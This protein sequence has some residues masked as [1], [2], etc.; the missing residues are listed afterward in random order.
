MAKYNVISSDSHVAEPGDLWLRYIDPAFRERAPQLVQEAD[1]DYWIC[2]GAPKGN[3]GMI[4]PAGRKSEELKAKGR[5][6]DGRAGGWDAEARLK[7]MAVDGVDAEVL[8]PTIAIR[9]FR[10]NDIDYQ[11]ACFRGYN[12]WMADFT[13]THPDKLKGLAL[14]T[15][16]DLERG[17]AQM[18]EGRALGLPGAVIAIS[19]DED[20]PYNHAYYEPLWDAAEDLAMPLS[21]HIQAGRKNALENNYLI[22]YTTTPYWVQRSLAQLIFGGVFERHP[23]LKVISAES[24]IGWIPT[25]LSRMDHAYNRH[26]FHTGGFDYKEEVP[27]STF[28]HR[29]VYATFMRD[30]PGVLAREYVGVGNL[31]WASDYPHS[32]STWPD[33]QRVIAEQFR[34]VP[35]GDRQRIVMENA[36]QLYGLNLN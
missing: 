35:V 14:V 31:M 15:V 3:A 18:R 11:D 19:P 25:F 9:M 26:R 2:E 24:D 21:L 10:L 17:I 28:F 22:D 34:D 1:A 13:G 27:P 32:D 4:A 30:A 5:Y 23:K 33:S 6:A 29:H 12:R 36:A 16:Q 8:Y 7:D 20:K